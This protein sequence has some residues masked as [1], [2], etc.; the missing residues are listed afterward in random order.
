MSSRCLRV[1][2]TDGAV[3]AS[4]TVA[5]IGIHPWFVQLESGNGQVVQSSFL[6]ADFHPVADQWAKRKEIHRTLKQMLEYM[7]QCKAQVQSEVK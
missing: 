2:K 1:T 4:P 3:G 6:W 7:M 5:L